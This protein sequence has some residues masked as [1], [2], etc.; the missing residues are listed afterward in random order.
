MT[1]DQVTALVLTY[2]EREN[3][4]RVV[5]RLAW[6]ARVLVLDSGSD[7]GTQEI[8][9]AFGNVRIIS[10]KFDNHANQWNYG[11]GSDEILTEWV[12]ALDADYVVSEAFREELAELEPE[13]GDAGYV[14]EFDYAIF[15]RSLRGSMYPRGTVL[16]RRSKAHYVQDGH[17]QRVVVD[18]QLHPL[19]SRI[20]HDDR[21]PLSRW[22][23]SQDRYAE[24]ELAHIADRS[25][26]SLG[27]PDRLRRFIIIMPW[28][29]PL[30]CLF[31][32][33]G[34]LDGYPGLYYALQRSIAESILALKLV[35]RYLDKTVAE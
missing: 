7:D 1:P 10:R 27:W 2:N 34:V 16:F 5:E 29:A 28:L 31:L 15:G 35:H 12:L 13:V 30:Y 33:L 17:T 14:A 24:L 19:K 4:G 22:L 32:R 23:V 3:I 6:A 20:V 11:L 9:A 21:K 18:G 26:R 8:A 25:F